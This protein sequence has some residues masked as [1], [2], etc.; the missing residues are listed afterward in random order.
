MITENLVI[1][2]EIQSLVE[3]LRVEVEEHFLAIDF[4][5]QQQ[6]IVGCQHHS[7]PYAKCYL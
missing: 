7:S 6:A 3:E 5:L 4:S 1:A 2:S